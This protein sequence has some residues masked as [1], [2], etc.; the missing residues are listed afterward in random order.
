ME[1]AS[2]LARQI[3]EAAATATFGPPFST[4]QY[5]TLGNI[6]I[7]NILIMEVK[8]YSSYLTS[9]NRYLKVILTLS[10]LL[11]IQ[12]LHSIIEKDFESY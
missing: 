12:I 11:K 9:I 6:S 1:M 4:L 7:R 3:T 5:V 8:L 2:F 10:L